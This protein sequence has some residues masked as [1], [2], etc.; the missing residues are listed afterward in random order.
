MIKD[1]KSKSQNNKVIDANID[2]YTLDLTM[3]V[4]LLNVML[5]AETINEQMNIIVT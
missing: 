4:Q 1:L 2:K 3:W 5:K